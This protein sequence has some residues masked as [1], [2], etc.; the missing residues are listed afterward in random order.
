MAQPTLGNN[1]VAPRHL[2][3]RRFVLQPDSRSVTTG[4]L[5]SVGLY[6]RFSG[7]QFLARR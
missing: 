4:G 7:G 1:G 2:D 5:P 3:M 6:G